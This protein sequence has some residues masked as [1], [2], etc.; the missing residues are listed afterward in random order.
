LLV[1]GQPA[2]EL[3]ALGRA[4]FLRRISRG[5][6]QGPLES[7]AQ[8]RLQSERVLGLEHD[9]NHTDSHNQGE[10]RRQASSEFVLTSIACR[11]PASVPS[12]SE[13]SESTSKLP[14]RWGKDVS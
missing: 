5:N 10:K 1:G 2:T 7:D 8:W 13:T 3:I 4:G 14:A 12:P 6:Y 9:C 11:A